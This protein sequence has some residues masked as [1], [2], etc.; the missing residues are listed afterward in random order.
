VRLVRVPRRLH[1]QGQCPLGHLS[2]DATAEGEP[3]MLDQLAAPEAEQAVSE[4][5][6]GLAARRQLGR[7]PPT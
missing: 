4:A 7:R 1:E 5:M 3:S 2:L 6:C